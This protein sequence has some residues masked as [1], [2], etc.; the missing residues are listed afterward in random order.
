MKLYFR[1][2]TLSVNNTLTIDD[3][4]FTFSLIPC[5][6]SINIPLKNGDTKIN[7]YKGV[8]ETDIRGELI[9]T[10]KYMSKHREIKILQ[11]NIVDL[12]KKYDILECHVNALMEANTL[13]N[14]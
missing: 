13:P 5:G 14:D 4:K 8:Y 3:I 11:K 9:N 12:Q 1:G 7:F 6:I 2:E 10:L